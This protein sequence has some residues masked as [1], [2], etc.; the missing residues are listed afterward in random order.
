MKRFSLMLAAA[1]AVAVFGMKAMAFTPIS[2]PDAAYLASTSYIDPSA[3]ADYTGVTSISDGMM[4]VSFKNAAGSTPWVVSKRTAPGGSWTTWSQAPD[5]QRGAGDTL[6]VF[7]SSGATN[8][9][10]VLSSPVNIFGFEAEPDPFSVHTM[11]AKFYD[12]SD[13]LL[14][15]ISRDVDGN[16][17]ARL[18]AASSPTPIA[19]V[20]FSSDVDWAVGAF[21]YGTL[22]AP[23]IPEPG[24]MALFG[25]GL[26]AGLL[27]L[28]RRLRA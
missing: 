1:V 19:Y 11:V 28:R 27:P 17:G 22:G 24:T 16:A 15:T 26:L 4:T 10:F 8:L 12:A 2:S 5:S 18:F 21:R 9:R 13:N 3:I 7:Y 25:T 23:V 14:G 6:P 20:V